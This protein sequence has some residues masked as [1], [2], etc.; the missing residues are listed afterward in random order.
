[1]VTAN[2]YYVSG[3]VCNYFQIQF[4]YLIKE[5]VCVLS[6]FRRVQVFATLWT[7]AHQA[8][9]SMGFSRQEYWSGLPCPP[10][11]DLPHPRIEPGS[12]VAPALQADSLLLSHRG[13]L[14]KKKKKKNSY[15]L[16]DHEADREQNL[17]I[18]LQNMVLAPRRSSSTMFSASLD[19]SS[20]RDTMY[21]F[22][23]LVHV[24]SCWVL[25]ALSS[26]ISWPDEED[27]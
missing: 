7:I 4:V 8:P 22:L 14:N 26:L 5:C 20:Q 9:L 11:G 3:L 16:L 23:A 13:S 19:C 18:W 25:H 27:G 1:M 12:P 17:A 2:A 15:Y 21:A 6:R 24:T 10:P